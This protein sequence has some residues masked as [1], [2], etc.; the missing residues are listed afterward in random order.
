MAD[1]IDPYLDEPLQVEYLGRHDGAV[2]ANALPEPSDV[3]SRGGNATITSRTASISDGSG[4]TFLK[5]ATASASG[6][7]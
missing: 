3:L 6:V 1:R 4:N 5:A 2:P 7:W